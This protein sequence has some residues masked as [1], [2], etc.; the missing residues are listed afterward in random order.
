MCNGPSITTIYNLLLNSL[1]LVWR[2]NNIRQLRYWTGPY[3]LLNVKEEMCTVNL[4]SGPIKFYSIVV[5]PY[6]TDFKYIQV[7]NI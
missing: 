3:N 5:K 6:L 7:K 4:L 2:E 1:I